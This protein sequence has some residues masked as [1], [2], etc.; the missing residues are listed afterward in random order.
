ME[1]KLDNNLSLVLED[2]LWKEL[3]K[4]Y[5]T[6][7]LV[8]HKNLDTLRESKQISYHGGKFTC[9]G[10]AETAKDKI[11]RDIEKDEDRGVVNG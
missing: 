3:C 4:R 11:I 1:L 6:I 10:L 7:L 8:T 5:D 2:D 9:V